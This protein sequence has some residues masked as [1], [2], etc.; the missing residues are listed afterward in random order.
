MSN[1]DT[2]SGRSFWS[3]LLTAGVYKRSQG[4][5]VRQV[6]CI[7]IW[8]IVILGVWR[9]WETYFRELSFE[10]NMQTV[11]NLLRYS[12]PMGLLLIGGW[13][14][15][16]L[17]NWPRFADFLISVE[18][19]MN[20]VS[21]PERPEWIKGSMVVMFTIGFMAALLFIYDLFWHLLFTYLKIS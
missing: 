18:A 16:R 19:E 15:Y 13:I 6:T 10:E 21:W 2:L 8:T 20:K 7:T 11:G 1:Q 14:G 4:R 3:E 17:V 5:I 12:V 9:L